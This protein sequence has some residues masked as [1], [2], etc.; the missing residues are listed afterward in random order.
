MRVTTRT[1]A[2]INLFI[3]KTQTFLAKFKSFSH[4][5]RHFNFNEKFSESPMRYTEMTCL[6]VHII[7]FSGDMLH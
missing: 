6:S 1:H 3:L 4:L 7:D 5:A 2:L